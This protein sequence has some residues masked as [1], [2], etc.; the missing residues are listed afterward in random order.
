MHSSN[1]IFEHPDLFHNCM[2]HTTCN[3]QQA[4]YI[5]NSLPTPT[6]M[7]STHEPTPNPAH[8]ETLD[9]GTTEESP[10]STE[11]QEFAKIISQ[12]FQNSMKPAKH[13]HKLRE[14]NTFDSSNPQML[15]TFILQCKLNLHDR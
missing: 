1:S 4:G 14:P 8:I 7:A 5:D 13:K 3:S 9:E 15:H 11:A 12:L 10:L 2:P 6:P